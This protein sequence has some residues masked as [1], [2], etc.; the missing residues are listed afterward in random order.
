MTRL[1]AQAW[2]ELFEQLVPSGERT[3][4]LG[5]MREICKEKSKDFG[6][7]SREIDRLLNAADK[8]CDKRLDYEEF[9]E[10]VSRRLWQVATRE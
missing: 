2:R 3:I 6:L 1:Y 5:D 9:V 4:T 8:N 10:L 7:S